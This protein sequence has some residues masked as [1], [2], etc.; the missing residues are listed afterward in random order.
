[1][2][3]GLRPARDTVAPLPEPALTQDEIMVAMH[4]GPLRRH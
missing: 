3:D 4:P 1:M 2:L